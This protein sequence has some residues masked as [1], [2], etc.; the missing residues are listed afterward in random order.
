MRGIL[1]NACDPGS[2]SGFA[3]NTSFKRSN[4]TFIS[5]TSRHR[6]T[7]L[8]MGRV[9]FPTS[10]L[11]ATNWPT[12]NSPLI[13]RWAPYQ[14]RK[15]V[16][17]VCS[18]LPMEIVAMPVSALRNWTFS[19]LTISPSSFQRIRRSA[20]DALTVPTPVTDS[21]ICESASADFSKA[22]RYCR[23]KIGVATTVRIT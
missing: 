8:R 11:K 3:S 19:D 10:R 23:L 13:T 9:T 7:T 20:A 4:A 6:S 1:I 16:F 17:T 5:C 12:D 15:T 2:S 22:S 18:M 21:T 14:K